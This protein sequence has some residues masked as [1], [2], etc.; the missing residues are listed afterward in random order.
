MTFRIIY[1]DEK[2]FYYKNT[3]DLK[4]ALLFYDNLSVKNKV[5]II[6]ETKHIVKQDGEQLIID[7]LMKYNN[8]NLY[9][10]EHENKYHVALYF[11]GHILPN[12]EKIIELQMNN[13]VNC[14][15]D[16]YIVTERKRVY[17]RF[18]DNKKVKNMLMC[19]D[20]SF[21]KDLNNKIILEMFGKY[22]KFV[23]AIC[24]IEDY[25]KDCD[26]ILKQNWKYYHEIIKEPPLKKSIEVEYFKIIKAYQL[27]E[28]YK[29]K[30]NIKYDFIVRTRPDL[31]LKNQLKFCSYY[32]EKSNNYVFGRNNIFI[33]GN[34]K[35]M[36]WISQL[37]NYYYRYRGKYGCER[38]MMMHIESKGLKYW[39]KINQ[40]T[41][42]PIKIFRYWVMN[43]G[44]FEAHT[45][46]IK[47]EDKEYWQIENY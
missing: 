16:I 27:K 20:K 15:Y 14:T 44:Y 40:Q 5:L 37:I 7:K 8:E 10:E 31:I 2:I 29:K 46:H 39:Y 22:S 17:G 45:K 9:Q 41:M 19:N 4:E 47:K 26:K 32:E 23:R 6:S 1:H 42:K 28:I 38:Q 21:L 35:N 43:S 30:M 11:L 36:D 18:K 25:Q 33:F 3:E 24:Y 13:Y 12:C 34:E